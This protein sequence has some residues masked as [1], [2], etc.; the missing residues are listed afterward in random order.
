VLRQIALSLYK[1]FKKKDGTQEETRSF[2]ASRGMVALF[3]NRFD[4]KNLKIIGEAASA[5]EEAAAM[6]LAEVKKILGKFHL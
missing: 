4:L 3:R 5:D 6:F 2:T 1:D